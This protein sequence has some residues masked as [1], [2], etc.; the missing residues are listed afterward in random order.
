MHVLPTFSVG[1]VSTCYLSCCDLQNGN[2]LPSWGVARASTVQSLAQSYFVRL[3]R[4]ALLKRYAGGTKRYVVGIIRYIMCTDR[5]Y[6]GTL[7]KDIDRISS[8]LY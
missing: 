5:P 6:G 8:L 4:C 2:Y 7:P 3:K 1:L